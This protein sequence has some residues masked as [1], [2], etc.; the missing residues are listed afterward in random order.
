M[1]HESRRVGHN[2]GMPTPVRPDLPPLVG[3]AVD[4]FGNRVRVAVIRSLIG[5]G[6]ATRTELSRRLGLSVS[7]LQK[8]ML[9]L[10]QSRVVSTDPPRSE[11]GRLSR[12]YVLDVVKLGEL[13]D[14]L[15]SAM[16]PPGH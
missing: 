8:H 9:A 12:R 3:D 7:L 16:T 14:A 15:T 10:E 1:C 11:P 13:R 6:S 5:E 4:V 2:R